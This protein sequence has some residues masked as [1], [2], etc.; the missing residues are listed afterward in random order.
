MAYAG[1]SRSEADISADCRVR[2]SKDVPVM[3][4]D[5]VSTKRVLLGVRQ[6]SYIGG[7]FGYTQVN[8]D[9]SCDVF[10]Q[11]TDS[12]R[13]G[14]RE[15]EGSSHIVA[16]ASS[17]IDHF[18]RPLRMAQ[19]CYAAVPFGLIGRALIAFLGENTEREKSIM[20][21]TG[22]E[23]NR[24]CVSST[25]GLSSWVTFSAKDRRHSVQVIT[26]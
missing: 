14:S 23:Q 12:F 10:G 9:F 13:C 18:H 25:S 20:Y 8:R 26:M 7:A 11:S 16:P 21:L 24:H 19:H 15:E 5:H 6:V 22:L 17:F 1:G 3:W 4:V 2:N